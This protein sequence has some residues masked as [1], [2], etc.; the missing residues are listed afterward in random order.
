MLDI[1]QPSP[2][3]SDSG[4]WLLGVYPALNLL[5]SVCGL[6]VYIALQFY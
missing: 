4:M 6:G 2:Q 5:A 1:G 3:M